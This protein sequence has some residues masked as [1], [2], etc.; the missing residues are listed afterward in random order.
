VEEKQAVRYSSG[1]EQ[2][3]SVQY[4]VVVEEEQAVIIAVEK[5]QAVR[6]ALEEKHLDSI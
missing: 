3:S 6:K 1:E 2:L 5:E 4:I